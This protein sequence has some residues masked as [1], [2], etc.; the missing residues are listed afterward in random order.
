[1]IK[2]LFTEARKHPS[3]IIFI[4]EIDSLCSARSENENESTRRVKTEFLVQ[5][6]GLSNKGGQLL[7]LGATNI[8]WG[9]DQAVKRRFEKRIY[10]PL[11]DHSA[12]LYMLKKKIEEVPFNITDAEF[13][14]LAKLA[15]NYSGSDIEVL[16]K[17]AAMEPLRFA[18]KTNKFRKLMNG[19]F[20]PVDPQTPAD[21][22]NVIQSTVYD[23]PD[24]SLELPALTLNDFRLSMKRSKCSVSLA[25]LKEFEDWTAQY[26]EE[27]A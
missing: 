3:A 4:D 17:D 27:G 2:V 16:C 18:Q 24:R 8:P 26:G 14:E 11:P 19:K 15:E 10:I 12:R 13:E 9:L 20:M 25:D 6:E 5:M 1:M 21:G 7:V 23:L 22:Y